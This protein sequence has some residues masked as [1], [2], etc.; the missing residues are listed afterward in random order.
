MSRELSVNEN[1]GT[2]QRQ[3]DA[4]T[5]ASPDS[6]SLRSREDDPP[7]LSVVLPTLDEEAGV[8]ECLRRIKRAAADLDV[9]VEVIVSDASTDRTPE[10]AREEGAVV[11]EPDEPGYGYAY[12]Y[13]FEHIRGDYVVIGDADTTYDFAELPKLYRHVADGDMDMAMGSRLEGEI[14]PGAM[15]ALHQ[16]VG[17]PL[18][19]A[20]LNV[21]YDADVSDA[22]SGFRVIDRD[23]LERLDLHSSGMEFASEMIMVAAEQDMT[24][25]EEPITYHEREGEATLDSFRDGWRHVKF[26]LVNA[27]AYLFSVPGVLVGIAGLLLMGIALGDVSVGRANF[28]VR[29]MILGSLLTIVGYQVT[30]FALFSSIASNPIKEGDDPIVR[31]LRGR[32]TLERGGIIGLALLGVGGAYA[33]ATV[34]R[35]I[36]SGYSVLPSLL[37]DV[38]AFTLI[39]VGLQTLFGAF[40]LSVL[41][42][43]GD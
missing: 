6:V 13:A 27:P 5:P 24:I 2:S 42:E 9:S 18:L 1:D 39:V 32:V 25:A 34:F 10:I 4:A 40:F 17:N 15:P 38:A 37:P 11:V 35:W 23:A 20:F 30:S 41:G 16:Y 22:H 36:V 8:R 3:S 43:R 31:W 19:T 7:V 29:T 21:F 26:M 33:G 28:G 12:Q 14:K